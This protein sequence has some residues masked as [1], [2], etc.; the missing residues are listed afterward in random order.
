MAH[1]QNAMNQEDKII[2]NKYLFNNTK[3][4]ISGFHRITVEKSS[5]PGWWLDNLLPKF[6]RNIRPSFLTNLKMKAARSFET[7]RH[8]YPNGRR[9][10]PVTYFLNKKT[11]LKRTSFPAVSFPQGKATTWPLH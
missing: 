6:R 8:N 3:S 9:N 5:L 1:L 7:S 2:K 4:V 10:N 11:S